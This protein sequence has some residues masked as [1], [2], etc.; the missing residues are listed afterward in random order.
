MRR[1]PFPPAFPFCLFESASF[2]GTLEISELRSSSTFD[3]KE[4]KGSSVDDFILFGQFPSVQPI[5]LK[6]NISKSGDE[7]SG[8]YLFYFTKT[9]STERIVL[10]LCGTV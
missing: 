9:S 1:G 10:Q 5:N 4:I 8:F 7:V 3:I 2:I 6:H